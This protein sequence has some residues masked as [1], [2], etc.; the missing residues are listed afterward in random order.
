MEDVLVKATAGDARIYAVTTT[1]L[2]QYMNEIHHCS[3]LAAAALGRTAAGALLLA[4][5]M[6]SG[7]AV[8]VRFKGDGPLGPV[9]ADARDY[10]V[11]GFVTHPEVMLPPKNGK[12]DVGGGVGH[13]GTVTVTRCP[14]VGK[15]FTGVSTIKSGEIAADLT[16]Y[17]AVS[18]QTPSSV[19]LGVLI[20]KDGSVKVSGGF[21]VQLLPDA[22]E[23]TI[24][25]LEDNILTLPYVTELLE[26]GLDAEGMIR[27]VAKGLE[28][29][30]LESHPVSFHCSCS[31]EKVAD[32]LTGLPEKDFDELLQDPKTEVHC[33]YCNQSYEFTQQELKELKQN[34]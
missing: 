8:T 30:I 4:A 23:T 24:K 10:T 27:K 6:K 5:T 15:P 13:Y 11:R 1:H 19:A 31:R 18:E 20:E 16:R 17:L 29:E 3:P 26:S 21:F 33:Q 28:V 9:M 25:T 32:M 14:L 2:T 34:A 12:L 7:E 22:A